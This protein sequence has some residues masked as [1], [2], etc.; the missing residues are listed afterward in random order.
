MTKYR[1]RESWGGGSTD[2]SIEALDKH[3]G[4]VGE[5]E[6]IRGYVYYGRYKT[7]HVAVL[8]KGTKG[9]IRM[10][11]FSWGYGGSGCQ[12]L[13]VILAKLKVPQEEIDRI[14]SIE[15]NG[16]STKRSS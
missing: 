16:W 15:W 12:G 2:R 4:K 10:G 6:S 9:T 1:Y 5:I 13:R 14:L 7:T 3:V 8:V 11:G